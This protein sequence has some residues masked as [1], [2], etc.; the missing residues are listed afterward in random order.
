MSLY[1][2]RYKAISS[3][4]PIDAKILEFYFIHYKN[5]SG[6]AKFIIESHIDNIDD[7]KKIMGD[8]SINLDEL[9]KHLNTSNTDFVD[10]IIELV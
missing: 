10:S 3:L 1:R 2:C 9:K 4:S 6:K 8:S 7:A 5:N